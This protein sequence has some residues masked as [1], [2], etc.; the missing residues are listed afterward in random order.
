[1]ATDPRALAAQAADTMEASLNADSASLPTGLA[2]QYRAGIRI[3]REAA[4]ST[5]DGETE[6]LLKSALSQLAEPP[7]VFMPDTLRR[8]GQTART[9]LDQA[10]NAT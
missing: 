6:A 1:M 3:A 5:D 7:T 2:E 9:L 8:A 10:R 4:A